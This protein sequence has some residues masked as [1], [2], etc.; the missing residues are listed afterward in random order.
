[1]CSHFPERPELTRNT[2]RSVLRS[3]GV[4]PENDFRSANA[5]TCGCRSSLFA[6]AFYNFICIVTRGRS[7]HLVCLDGVFKLGKGMSIDRGE[8]WHTIRPT[9]N[10]QVVLFIVA[11]VFT[12]SLFARDNTDVLVM[13]NGD[14]MT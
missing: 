7:R 8:K 1:M 14:R 12:K 13:K 9:M 3:D 10:I 4:G 5:L 11:L 2:S 6:A